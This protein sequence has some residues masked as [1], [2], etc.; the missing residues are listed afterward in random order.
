[1]VLCQEV[2][3]ARRDEHFAAVLKL[4]EAGETHVVSHDWLFA[5]LCTYRLQDL[6][7]FRVMKK[8]AM[9]GR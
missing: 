8:R 9:Y 5:S 6:V 1:V 7:Q 4:D 3:H 2:G